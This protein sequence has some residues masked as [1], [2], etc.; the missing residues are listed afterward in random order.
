MREKEWR[1]CLFRLVS[2]SLGAGHGPTKSKK[3]MTRGMKSKTFAFE[4]KK[5]LSEEEENEE[6]KK[7]TKDRRRKKTEKDGRSQKTEED[8]EK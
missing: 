4:H 5:K 8:E 7:K 3:W 1:T 6:E 2:N